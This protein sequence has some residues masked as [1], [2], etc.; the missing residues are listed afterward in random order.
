MTRPPNPYTTRPGETWD[1]RIDHEWRVLPSDSTKRCR[2]GG[3]KPCGR[4]AVAELNRGRRPWTQDRDNWWA[5]CEQHLYSRWIEDG[6][7]MEW[8]SGEVFTK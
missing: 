4:P 5:Y 6:Q 2:A 3:N 7:V 8:W 1:A